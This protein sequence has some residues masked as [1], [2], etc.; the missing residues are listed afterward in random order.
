[1]ADSNLN[2]A[3]V[4]PK[5]RGGWAEMV[6]CCWLLQ[7]G[8]EVFRNVS[9]HGSIDVVAIKD[10][11]VFKFDVKGI[12]QNYSGTPSLKEEQL[13]IGVKALVVYEDGRVIIVDNQVSSK[14]ASRVCAHCEKT[15]S[16]KRRNQIYCSVYCQSGRRLTFQACPVCKRDFAPRTTTQVYCGPDCAT[17]VARSRGKARRK[18]VETSEISWAFSPQSEASLNQDPVCGAG[19]A[20]TKL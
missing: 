16:P 20:I 19:K 3:D 4:Q 2:R 8:Y 7:R 13:Q 5:H 10:G 6:A 17:A 1:M 15:Y 9:A 12:T 14:S 11:E 18:G